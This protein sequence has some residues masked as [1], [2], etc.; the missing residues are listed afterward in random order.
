[1]KLFKKMPKK[2]WIILGVIIL[3]VLFVLFGLK[4]QQDDAYSSFV[5]EPTTVSDELLLAGII[6]AQDRV[7]LGF[8]TSGRV[9]K[10]NFQ[11]GERVNKGQIIAEVEQNRLTADLTQAQANLT[12]TRVDTNTEVTSAEDSVATQLA[13]QNAIVEGLYREYLSGDLQAYNTSTNDRDAAAP[14]VTGTYDGTEEGEYRIDM[15]S[16]SSNSGYSFRLSGIESDT[17]TAQINNPGNL[18]VNGLYIQF[19]EGN[20]YGNTQWVVPVP[21]TRSAT[22]S[23]RKRAYESA[24]ATRDRIISDAQN[25]LDRVSAVDSRAQVTRDE[26]KRAQA[27]AQVNAVA[28]QLGDGKVRAP[29]TGIIAKNDLE[30]GEIVTAFTPEIVLFGGEEKELNLNTPE[31]YINK[32]TLGDSVD[33]TLDAYEDIVLTG[34]VDFIDFIDTE[35]DG[36]PVYRTEIIINDLDDRIRTG[37][38]AKASIISEQRTDVLAVPAHYLSSDVNGDTIVTVKKSDRPNDIEERVVTT[39]LR[40]NEGLVEIIDG[41]NQGEIILVENS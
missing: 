30:V 23:T 5:V 25:N 29:F 10:V 28:A 19:I 16:S 8:A 3:L 4:K 33:V 35:V 13:E 9:S 1:M 15:Y 24:L 22:Y 2:R 37:M 11:V 17:Y 7:D 31:I 27:Q 41:L 6:D 26:A 20:S 36:V 14:I 34:T 32:I 18:G 38:N 40:G 21:N 12:L 39:G